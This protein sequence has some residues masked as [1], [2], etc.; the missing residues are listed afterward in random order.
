MKILICQEE[1][2][3]NIR[4][5][6]K[7]LAWNVSEEEY[8]ADPAISYSTIS[9]FS[10]EGWRK[11]GNLYTKQDTPQ[12]TFG[13]IVDCLLTEPERFDDRFIIC[14][15][16]PLSDTLISITKALYASYGGANR[17]IS[18]IKDTFINEIALSNGYYSNP[19]YANYR[20]KKVKEECEIYYS[21]LS[22]AGNKTVVTQEDYDDANECATELRTNPLTQM[23]FT[24]FEDDELEI[25]SQ[26]KFR[27]NY[28]GIP[29][30]C[31]FD[32]IVVDHK[33]KD[34]Y[35]I[36]LKTTGHP[37]E[38]FEGSFAKWRYDI[39]AGLY[40]Y[41]LKSVI[42]RDPY[43]R[44]F[45]IREYQFVTINRITKAPIIWRFDKNFYEGDLKDKDGTILKN[46]RKILE[47]LQYYLLNPGTR[48][49]KEATLNNYIMDISNLTEV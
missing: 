48:Y 24:V 5:S 23:Y 46:W 4:R 17:S 1:R 9:R 45:N 10:R 36:D 34:I 41:I 18:T 40:S 43:F 39:Q 2:Q 33:N 13:S 30:R 11:I 15:F 8:R 20:A 25:V 31:M 27:S 19:K 26:L 42:T 49:S 47:E 7:E 6:I 37:E 32:V 3:M 35:P 44:D 29:V 28:Y 38:E 12:L 22:V 21:L 14:S 16:P